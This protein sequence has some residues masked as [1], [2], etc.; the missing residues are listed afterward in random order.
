M[1]PRGKKRSMR[2]VD[3]AGHVPRSRRINH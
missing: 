2:H 1:E 3:K